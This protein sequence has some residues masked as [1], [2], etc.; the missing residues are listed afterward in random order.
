M[1]KLNTKVGVLAVTLNL[2]KNPG[3]TA[4]P[5]PKFAC[6]TPKVHA[7]PESTELLVVRFQEYERDA[8]AAEATIQ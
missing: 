5:P 4:Q 1:G 2:G 7:D 8:V 3:S 6:I